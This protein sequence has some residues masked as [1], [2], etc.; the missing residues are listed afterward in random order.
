MH[1]CASISQT[2]NLGIFKNTPGTL[3]ETHAQGSLLCFSLS[4]KDA[5][6]KPMSEDNKKIK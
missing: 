6:S 2:N 1:D 3:E 4:S 5:L